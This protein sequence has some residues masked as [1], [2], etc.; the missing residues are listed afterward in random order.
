MGRGEVV[1]SA[2][3]GTTLPRTWFGPGALTEPA[4]LARLEGAGGLLLPVG[5]VGAG[6]RGSRTGPTR[7]HGTGVGGIDHDDAVGLAVEAAGGQLTWAATAGHRVC[8]AVR[9][10]RP[11]DLAAPLQQLLRHPDGGAVGAVEVDLRG[12][13]EQTVLRATA[14]VREAV[15]RTLPVL[16]KVLAVDPQLVAVARSAVAGGAAAVVVSGQVPLGGRRWW[17][18]PSTAATTRAGLRTLGAAATEHRWPGAF[19][20]AAGGV[21]STTTVRAALADGADGV[22]LGTAMW[23][24]PTLLPALRS[25]AES[26]PTPV[27]TP[28]PPRPTTDRRSP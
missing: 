19:L 16:V 3:R 12:S 10:P 7:V 28:S 18:G 17:S 8:L 1:L 22:Q 23:A 20:V 25:A 5:P 21:H 24:D 6:A 9:G 15:G 11:E 13:D 26:V 14:R 4:A 2:E 27:P